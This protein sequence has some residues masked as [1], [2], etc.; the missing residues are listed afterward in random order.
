MNT[1]EVLVMH[2]VFCVRYALILLSV[3]QEDKLYD[4]AVPF[5]EDR[6]VRR[7]EKLLILIETRNQNIDFYTF[8][9][10]SSRRGHY[11]NVQRLN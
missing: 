11:E 7:V 8:E 1:D 10:V 6:D 5:L 4:S 3:L 9:R 2:E